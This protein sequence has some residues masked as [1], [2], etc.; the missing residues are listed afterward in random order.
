MNVPSS[1]VPLKTSPKP[2]EP[3]RFSLEKLL[4]AF[5]ISLPENTLADF[6][7][8]LLAAFRILVD[9]TTKCAL[10]LA[11][12]SSSIPIPSGLTKAPFLSTIPRIRQAQ[13]ERQLLAIQF[14]FTGRFNRSIPHQLQ[15]RPRPLT[16]RQRRV[17]I[18]KALVQHIFR[19]IQQQNGVAGRDV[20]REV[21]VELDSLAAQAWSPHLGP[22]L[23]GK[24]TGVSPQFP[25][26]SAA[27][28]VGPIRKMSANIVKKKN[29]L[30]IL[31]IPRNCN[32]GIV[33]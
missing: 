11:I 21:L 33:G 15:P 17:Q 2:P 20:E 30:S 16:Q 28:A 5:L 19:A 12:S 18:H 7:L 27:M 9:I 3:S 24:G 32:V 25:H 6:P 13:R 29:E 1:K 14:R 23:S 22:V 26:G 8:L 10:T 31:D 4:V